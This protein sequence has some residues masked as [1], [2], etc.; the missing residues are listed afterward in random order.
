LTYLVTE[1]D[2]TFFIDRNGFSHR[3]IVAR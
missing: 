3:G 2:E 1:F